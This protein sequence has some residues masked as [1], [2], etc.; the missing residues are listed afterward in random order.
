[1]TLRAMGY[2][3]IAPP[4]ESSSIPDI[5]IDKLRERYKSMIVFYDRDKAGEVCQKNG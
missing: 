2:N 4:S 1:M 5:V 3:S